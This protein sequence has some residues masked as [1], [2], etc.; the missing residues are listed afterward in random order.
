M[1]KERWQLLGGPTGGTIMALALSPNF[2]QDGLC[3]AATRVGLFRSSDRGRTWTRVGGP[4]FQP[5]TAVVVSPGYEQD[6]T[7]LAGTQSGPYV[8]RD[9]GETWLAGR[10]QVGP[11][12]ALSALALSP[13]FPRDGIAFA[14]TVQDGIFRSNDRGESWHGWNFGLL[15]LNVL[16]VAVSPAFEQDETVFAATTTA[17]FRSKNGGRAW[18]EVGFPHAAS[19]VLSLALSPTFAEDGT[20]FAG[21]EAAGV[22]RSTDRGTT[23]Q[24]LT[25]LPTEE[26]INGLAVSPAFARDRTVLA[27][28]DGGLYLSRD[29]GETWALCAELPGALC[30]AA[31]PSVTLVGL[32]QEGIWRA[33]NGLER[34][35]PAS[36]GLAARAFSG[37]ALSPA[38][39]QDGTLFIYGPGEGLF[40]SEDGGQTWFEAVDGLPSLDVVALA[41]SPDFARDGTAYAALAE[42]VCRSRDRGRH[43]EVVSDLPA[44]AVALSPGFADDGTV[45][46]GTQGQGV[47]LSSDRG[48]SW[49][50]LP[51]PSEAQTVGALALSPTFP[52]SGHLFLAAVR[53][54]ERMLEVW[55][56]DRRGTSWRRMVARDCD[57]GW[58]SLAVSPAYAKDGQWF[59]AAGNAIYRPPLLAGRGR[60]P[61]VELVAQPLSSERPAALYVAAALDGR[62]RLHLFAAS[63]VGVFASQDVGRQWQHLTGEPSPGPTLAVAPSPAYARDRQVYALALGGMIWRGETE[64]G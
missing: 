46:V 56:G 21:T 25:G 39:A 9:G 37:F 13:A 15:D 51:A 38:L 43:W 40:C 8:S 62:S 6:R 49:Q 11:T 48:E 45:L 31:S 14:G 44:L 10:F 52:T 33:E 17:L 36:E 50:P 3:W 4:G 61:E 28:T 29:A 7:L 12:A 63:P 1:A 23:W 18:R 59:V 27:L 58:V 47:L 32:A 57:G 41:L 54:E 19:P 60:G 42:G 2:A 5:M 64:T 20:L 16:T 34:W 55:D 53:A 22:F 30:L 24:A 26:S 35:Q